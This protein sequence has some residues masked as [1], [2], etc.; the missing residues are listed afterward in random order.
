MMFLLLYLNLSRSYYARLPTVI[1]RSQKLITIKNINV[2]FPIA[3]PLISGSSQPLANISCSIISM[4]SL[5]ERLT[6]LMFQSYWQ[7]IF[8]KYKC[9]VKKANTLR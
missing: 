6:L 9:F 5:Y 1:F 3:D 4:S 8:P 7:A 2:P